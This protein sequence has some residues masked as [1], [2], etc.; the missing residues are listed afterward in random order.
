VFTALAS[1]CLQHFQRVMRAGFRLKAI[2]TAE[3]Y[4]KVRATAIFVCR[5]LHVFMCAACLLILDLAS[6]V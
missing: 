6:Q 5:N 1:V 4:R 2:L 3:V